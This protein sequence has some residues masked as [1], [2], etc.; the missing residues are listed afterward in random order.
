MKYTISKTFLGYPFAHRQ[1]NHAG[2]CALIHGHNWDFT[3]ELSAPEG[4]LDENDFVYDFGK[5][6]W[7]KEW[8]TYMFDHTCVINATD[9]LLENFKE[10]D[11]QNLLNLRIVDSASAEGL[12]KL[13]YE[14]I[15][16]KDLGDNVELVS[17]T[18]HEDYKNSAKYSA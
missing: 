3:V 7:L 16:T 11:I 6:A 15:K 14:F 12:A 4:Q 8:L 13:V 17:V 5:F 9:P 18:V 2:H 1:P 10:L